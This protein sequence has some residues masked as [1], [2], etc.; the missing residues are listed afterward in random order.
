MMLPFVYPMDAV[1]A[2]A[3]LLG[4]HAVTATTGDITSVLFGIPGE[5]T[6]A[7]TVFDGYPMT[8]RGEGGRALGAVLFSSLI[9]ALSAPWCW[10][11]RCRSS[12]PWCCSWVRRSS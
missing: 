4:M 7:A 12:D 11:S 8:R 10:R 2:F 1:S 9:G 6:S 3:F 5:A